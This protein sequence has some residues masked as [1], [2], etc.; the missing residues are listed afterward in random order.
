LL[1]TLATDDVAVS[2]AQDA[3]ELT[4]LGELIRKAAT[5]A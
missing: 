5:D 2:E 1:D 3:R 4:A